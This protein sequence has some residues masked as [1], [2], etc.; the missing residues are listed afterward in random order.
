M[1]P[2][3]KLHGLVL[4]GF[5]TL[6]QSIWSCTLTSDSFNPIEA[7]GSLTPDAGAP[8]GPSTDLPSDTPDDDG[9]RPCSEGTEGV[10]CDI[11]IAMPGASCESDTDCDSQVC[12]DGACSE[13]TCRDARQNGDEDG[14]DCGGPCSSC[15]AGEC[16]DDSDCDS[17]NCQ[18]GSCVD[19]TCDDGRQ[20]QGEAGADCAG[21]CAA[22]CGAGDTCTG[23]ADCDDGLFCPAS[24][25]RCTTVSCQDELQNGDELQTDCGGG[26]CPG[27]AVGSP[28]ENGADCL[29]LVCGN[30][31]TCV[32]ATCGDD[33]RNQNETGV[34]CGGPCPDCATG[35]PCGTG[36]DC[37]SGVCGGGG[38]GQ[39]VARCCQAPSC[40]DD[41]QNGTES[42]TDCGNAA[43]G[44]CGNG[45]SCTANGQCTS[46]FCQQGICRQPP[47]ADGVQNGTETDTDCGGNDTTCRR[48]AVGD[49]CEVNGDCAS[50]SCIAGECAGCNDGQQNGTETDTDCGGVCGP[51]NAGDDCDADADCD[52]NVCEAGRCC[53][54][55]LVDCTRC[56]RRLVV[57]YGSTISCNT[58]GPGAVANCEAFLNCL[59]ANPNQCPVR[60]AP[61]CSDEGGVC[62]HN[63][64]GTNFG[65]GIG[66]ADAILGTA[67]CTF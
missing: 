49:D 45:D 13:P 44:D 60:H 39:G 33:V 15:T 62:N 7:T 4:V 40:N 16:D 26:T 29:T 57:A 22:R 32:A 20:N 31:D 51:C 19:A 54:G 30:A 12:V 14:V 5:A 42:D 21:P 59:A 36:A 34:D 23:N 11:G 38:C 27:C 43:C 28:C 18:A 2:T 3:P 37:Q 17:N 64:F 35:Q 10:G 52:T 1:S 47:C 66:L 9:P 58:N 46:N 63:N 24:T 8:P 6:V 25:Q 50:G 67:A 53:G 48:C 61:G 56:A 41:I 55:N 65:E